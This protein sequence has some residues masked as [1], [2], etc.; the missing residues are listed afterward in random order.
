ML[1][2]CMASDALFFSHEIQTDRGRRLK[3][4]VDE[5]KKSLT[6]DSFS[7]FYALRSFRGIF[8]VDNPF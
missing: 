7:E 6:G 4:R 3:M 8:V 5:D 2:L 1:F